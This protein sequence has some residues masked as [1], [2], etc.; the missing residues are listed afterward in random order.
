MRFTK[1]R[2]PLMRTTVANSVLKVLSSAVKFE[3]SVFPKSGGPHVVVLG[4]LSFS[5]MKRMLVKW[6]LVRFLSIQ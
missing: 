5:P 6:N 3:E 1:E 2:D 4:V